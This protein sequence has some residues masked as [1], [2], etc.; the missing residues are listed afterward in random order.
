MSSVL[1]TTL[2]SNLIIAWY[3]AFGKSE[4]EQLVYTGFGGSHRRVHGLVNVKKDNYRRYKGSFRTPIHGS[5]KLLPSSWC[6][7]EYLFCSLGIQRCPQKAIAKLSGDSY[8]PTVFNQPNTGCGPAL[9]PTRGR[10]RRITHSHG[11]HWL[12]KSTP[13]ILQPR[14][15]CI[16]HFVEPEEVSAYGNSRVIPLS[17][18]GSRCSLCSIRCIAPVTLLTQFASSASA[19]V[20]PSSPTHFLWDG[21]I[22]PY[23]FFILGTVPLQNPRTSLHKIPWYTPPLLG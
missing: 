13:S 20:L 9:L 3:V 12:D 14:R 6:F 1:C 17:W 19:L 4:R 16:A 10:C 5:G 2:S 23:C 22:S 18:L 15:E 8:Q 21:C 7:F 11:S